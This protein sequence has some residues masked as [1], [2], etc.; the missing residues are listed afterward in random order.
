MLYSDEASGEA[1]GEADSMNLV[2]ITFM[3]LSSDGE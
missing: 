3:T 2:F 1:N